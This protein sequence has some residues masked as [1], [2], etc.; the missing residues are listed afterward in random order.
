AIHKDDEFTPAPAAGHIRRAAGRFQFG[1]KLLQQFIAG[2]M[3]VFVVH[4]F[5][6]INV[7]D[8]YAEWKPGRHPPLK[9]ALHA[10]AAA[11]SGERIAGSNLF[12][13]I[14][15]GLKSRYLGSQPPDLLPA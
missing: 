8:G 6:S 5:E 14:Q 7:Y 15:L 4:A 11:Q 9:V 3:S 2:H 13:L 1:S 12:G 10:H